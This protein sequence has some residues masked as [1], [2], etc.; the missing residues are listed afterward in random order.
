VLLAARVVGAGDTAHVLTLDHVRRAKNALEVD[1]TF[2][3]TPPASSTMKW[4]M[5]LAVPAPLAPEVR[6]KEDGRLVCTLKPEAGVW[7]TPPQ[8]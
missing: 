7:I 8:R 3:P 5:A 1:Y 6:F 4:Y 2:H